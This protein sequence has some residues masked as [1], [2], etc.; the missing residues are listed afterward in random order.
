MNIGSIIAKKRDKF[1]LSK[2]EID[3]FVKGYT[4]GEIPDYQMSAL[5]MAIY[6]NDL[7]MNEII[8]LTDAMKN[9]GDVIQLSDDLGIKVDKHST[10]GVG[11]KTTLVV[12]PIVA[13]AG[14][15]ISKMSGRGL[16]FTGGTADKLD[17]IPGFKNTLTEAELKKQ[18]DEI[19]IAL[20]TQTA[21]IA[22][23]DKKIYAL[24]DVT[25]TVANMGLIASSIMS[26]KLASGDDVIVL[27]VKCGSGAFMQDIE[28]ATKLSQIM[29]EIGNHFNKKTVA[30][31]SDMNNPL[32]RAVGNSLEV[33]ESIELLKGKGPSDLREICVQLSAMMIFLAKKASSF[34]EAVNMSNELLDN[35][36]AL[37]KFKKVVEKQGGDMKIF[38]DY[39]V[40][41]IASTRMELISD[42]Q[43]YVNRIDAKSVGMASL[44]S[45]AGRHSKEDEIDLSAGIL[46]EKQVGEFVHQGEVLASIYGNNDKKVK[47]AF[48]IMKDSFTI[49][50]E[51]NKE[52]F[53]I[54]KVIGM[55]NE[56]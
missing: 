26:K 37:E 51:K 34:D 33:I 40:F 14:V 36:K 21:N 13:A 53:I 2:E 50:S 9:S 38:E 39:S 19:G 12:A 56:F 5:L 23:A 3:F 27:D 22:P 16:G 46:I 25:E 42:K 52:D 11:D 54:K 1:E 30:M 24:R 4:L 44:F 31:I 17:S 47:E 8:N 48:D 28:Q 29:V 41:P 43:G 45:G 49:S 6:I 55:D 7:S 35:G 10:G 20:L 18:I 15:N 32:G